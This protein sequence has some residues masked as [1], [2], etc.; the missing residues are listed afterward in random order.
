MKIC[1]AISLLCALTMLL[2]RDYP[3]VLLFAAFAL[4]FGAGVL[5]ETKPPT[6][7]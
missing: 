3:M 1:C 4:L 2:T 6:D 5:T 7:H